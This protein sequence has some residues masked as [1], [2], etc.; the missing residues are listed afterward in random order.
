MTLAKSRRI[1][2]AVGGC[3]RVSACH[4]HEKRCGGGVRGERRAA[5]WNKM[6]RG[7]IVRRTPYMVIHSTIYE[8]E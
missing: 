8:Y 6:A 3:R 2:V 1:L 7:D 5:A 4:A